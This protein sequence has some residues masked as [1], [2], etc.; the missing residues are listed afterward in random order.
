MS[1]YDEVRKEVLKRIDEWLVLSSEPELY[2]RFCNGYRQGLAD[3][4]LLIARDVSQFEWA[5]III[6]RYKSLTEDCKH[7]NG[8]EWEEGCCKGYK[9]VLQCIREFNK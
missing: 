3:C 1:G 6:N 2:P 4:K 5:I 7:A 8:L 9:R